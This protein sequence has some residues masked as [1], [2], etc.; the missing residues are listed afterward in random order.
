MSAW[1]QVK[2]ESI[3]S[4]QAWHN[5][6]KKRIRP[7]FGQTI[8]NIV[9]NEEGKKWLKTRMDSKRGTS[10]DVP[11]TVA[12]RNA[13]LHGRFQG[14]KRNADDRSKKKLHPSALDFQ[15]G[16]QND[17]GA[18]ELRGAVFKKTK[19]DGGDVMEWKPP[20]NLRLDAGWTICDNRIFDLINVASR[21]KGPLAEAMDRRKMTSSKGQGRA[22]TFVVDYIIALVLASEPVPESTT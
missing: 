11:F 12:V 22:A 18:N 10:A 16:E 1:S 20:D 7:T 21:D 9:K 2:N 17:G 15:M 14:K 5:T 4:K 3:I 6:I 8:K 13:G 19:K